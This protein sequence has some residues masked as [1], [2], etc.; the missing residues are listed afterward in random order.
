MSFQYVLHRWYEWLNVALLRKDHLFLQ[1]YLQHPST[2]LQHL[3]LQTLHWNRMDVFHCNRNKFVQTVL[4][5]QCLNEFW[6]YWIWDSPKMHPMEATSMLLQLLC[7][8][9][10]RHCPSSV[11]WLESLPKAERLFPLRFCFQNA[12]FLS[13]ISAWTCV[14]S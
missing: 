14:H 2:D 12:V 4:C 11:Y 9:N 5:S 10:Q 1:W 13:P 3:N 6:L 7:Q 8:A